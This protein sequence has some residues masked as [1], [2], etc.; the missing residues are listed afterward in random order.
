MLGITAVPMARQAYATRGAARLPTSSSILARQPDIRLVATP[1]PLYR[2]GVC[3]TPEAYVERPLA[4][5]ET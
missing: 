3:R 1:V 5:A 4:R 2:P